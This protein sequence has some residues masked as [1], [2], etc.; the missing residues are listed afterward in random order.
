MPADEPR[1]SH[2]GDAEA[3]CQPQEPQDTGRAQPDQTLAH[4]SA[5][6]ALCENSRG[7]SG[8]VG[9]AGIMSCLKKWAYCSGQP[10]ALAKKLGP[11]Q[12]WERS[13]VDAFGGGLL[14]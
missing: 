3:E 5:A 12:R 14:S 10:S 9:L 7:L 11:A 13:V 2:R 6:P 8:L 4:S 1:W